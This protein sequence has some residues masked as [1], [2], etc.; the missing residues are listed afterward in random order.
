MKKWDKKWDAFSP[1]RRTDMRWRGSHQM[2][3]EI[4]KE[5]RV[6]THYYV[7]VCEFIKVTPKGFNFLIVDSPRP[8][9]IGICLSPKSHMYSK[10]HVGYGKKIPKS[11][12]YI[13]VDIPFWISNVEPYIREGEESA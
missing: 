13:T 11:C 10:K 7:T 5:Y 12:R 4:G 2:S 6:T 3:L 9:D 1:P 8:N